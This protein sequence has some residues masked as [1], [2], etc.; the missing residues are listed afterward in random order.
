MGARLRVQV[1]RLAA[2]TRLLLLCATS[3]DWLAGWLTEEAA[4]SAVP[5]DDDG[6]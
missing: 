3:A 1:Q 6:G 5:V 4:L 2:C